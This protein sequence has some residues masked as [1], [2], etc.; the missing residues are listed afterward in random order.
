MTNITL[1]FKGIM[2][3][4]TVT[5]LLLVG[6]SVSAIALLE[7]EIVE[8]LGAHNRQASFLLISKFLSNAIGQTSGMKD[9]TALQVLIEEISELRPGI[10]R[11]SIFDITAGT[12]TRLVTTNIQTAP[13]TLTLKDLTEIE[14]GRSVMILDTSTG[15]RAWHITVPIMIEDKVVGA[16]GGLFSISEYDELIAQQMS[17]AKLV[18]ITLLGATWLTFA[19]LVR[20][21]IHRPIQELLHAMQVIESGDLSRRLAITGPAE[22]AEVTVQFNRMLDHVQEAVIE[23]DG[24]LQEVR[25]FNDTLRKRIADATAELQRANVELVETRLAVER[26]QR[27]AVLGELSATVAHE[28]GNPLNALSGH[29]QMLTNASDSASRERHLTVIRSEVRRMVSI[30]KQ[31]LE[32]THVPLR[33]TPVN[34]NTLIQ[35]VLTLFTPTLSMKLVTLRT[36]FQDDLLPVAGDSRALHGLI[37]NLVTNAKQ[38]MP[39]GGELA[40]QT[41]TVKGAEFT[42]TAEVGGGSLDDGAMMVRLVISDTGVGIPS[43]DLAR[44]FEPFFT[45]RRNEGGTGLGLAICHRVVED[46]GGKI[47]VRSEVGW[48]TEFTIDLPIWN[49]ERAKRRF[50]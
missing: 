25:W 12:S 49:D 43:K 16:L 23:K 44:I 50:S 17:S 26:S 10:Q 9:V 33:S 45:T 4:V 37:F 24:L 11:L 14:A 47:F 42:R 2:V 7:S 48:G 31:L 36:D 13:T 3:W 22:I 19:V 1:K 46:C 32:Q 18:G 27:L 41:L 21:K 20:I 40:I 30:I 34:L 15:E 35:E 28:L 8:R 38:S 6:L 29:L 5:G 39:V